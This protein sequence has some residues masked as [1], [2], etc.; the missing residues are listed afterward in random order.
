MSAIPYDS[1]EDSGDTSASEPLTTPGRP[2]RHFLNRRSAA[3]AAAVTC[4]V[5]FYVGVTVEK[6][7]L[8]SG[9][10]S[11]ATA[12]TG[13]GATARAG[14]G[15][16]PGAGGFGAGAGAG[17]GGDASA[18][19]IAS[20]DGNTIYLTESSGNT[21]KVKLA[22]STKLTKSSSVSKSSLHPGDTV[23]IQ[24]AT[25]AN[26]T[27]SATSISDSGVR[28]TGSSTTGSSTTAG[29]SGSTS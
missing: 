10:S 1:P 29:D 25:G 21:V 9:T 4:A 17:A 18:G 3:L 16:F 14:A 6:G 5:G 2:R 19:T 24:G 12:A 7:Q 23:V 11:A 26:G 28:T 27:V 15:G 22:S 20:V 13:A 8:S